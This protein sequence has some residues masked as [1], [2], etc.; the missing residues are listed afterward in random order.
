MVTQTDVVSIMSAA[1][2][3]ILTA[4]LPMLLAALVIGLVVSIFQ[5]T[6]QI[7]EQTLSFVPKIIGIL[8]ALLIFAD[9]IMS[10]ISGFTTDM[11]SAISTM[12][13]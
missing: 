6:T 4:S 10:R 1:V 7:N 12:L 13:R 3:T 8:F 5:A 2:Y 9:W 11:F